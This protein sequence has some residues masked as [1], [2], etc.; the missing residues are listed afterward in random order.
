MI[1]LVG[2]MGAGKSTVGRLLA[3]ELGVAFS[4][5]DDLI[6]ERAGRSVPEIFAS[7]GA[8]GFR[9][10][11]AEVIPGLLS[12]RTGVVALGG[13]AVEV[14]AV[15]T[16]LRGH[17]VVHLDV[18][19]EEAL[20]RVE[21]SARPM[22]DIADP[23]TLYGTRK[24]LY[25]R[26]STYTVGTGDRAPEAVVREI[27][28]L[29][30]IG[31]SRK[32]VTVS[33]D[34]RAYEVHVGRGLLGLVA[35]VV[36][37]M[38][39]RVAILH[40][41]T[42]ENHAKEV[43]GSFAAHGAECLLAEVP[44]REEAKSP[45]EIVRLWSLLS[46]VEIDRDDMIVTVGGGAVTDVGGFVASTYMRGIRVVHVPTTLLGQVD[47]AV[48]GKTAVNLPEAKNLI[49]TIYQPEVVVCDLNTL[50]TVPVAELRSGS[51]EIVKY[52]LISAPEL[53]DAIDAE[54]SAILEGDAHALAPI[55]ERCVSI[56]AEVVRDDESD[57]G[58]R[59]ILN[60]GHTFGHAFEQRSGFSMRHGEAVALGMMA[61][62]FTAAELGWLDDAG[63]E[64]H[65]KS[66]QTLG[67]PTAAAFELEDL[68]EAWKLD[69]KTSGT[70]RF[71]LLEGLGLPRYDV[72]VEDGILR[73]ALARLAA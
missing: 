11:E 63:V 50:A 41:P 25:E 8:S 10:L 13:G 67:L 12:G 42:V 17:E 59:K 58:Q 71:V 35:D 5:S 39:R 44:D 24:G 38:P 30:E 26:V 47:A 49:G 40:Q 68:V 2:F 37:R 45:G 3:Q 62:A 43:A 53:L 57:A 60:Y 16:A 21:G 52:G 54:A 9:R 36:D 70:P 19:L 15:T 69:K 51:A 4:D 7:E 61:A 18:P 32:V 73:T 33:A 34:S 14:D 27:L 64:R 48:G 6:T 1:V 20:N 55:V 29:V 46:R 31:A 65:R 28:E 22:L 72:A 56:K 23:K 66:L